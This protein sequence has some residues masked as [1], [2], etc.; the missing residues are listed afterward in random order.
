[1]ISIKR[2]V[3]DDRRYC[4]HCGDRACF[5]INWCNPRRKIEKLPAGVLCTKC[6]RKLKK[7]V[8]ANFKRAKG[9]GSE[10]YREWLKGETRRL[11]RWEEEHTLPWEPRSI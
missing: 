4:S 1:M 7:A 2:I 6:M 11:D 5:E 9:L 3:G 10:K 8:D